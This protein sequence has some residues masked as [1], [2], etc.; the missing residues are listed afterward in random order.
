MPKRSRKT[1]LILLFFLWTV[2]V[3]PCSGN[4]NQIILNGRITDFLGF[5]VKYTNIYFVDQDND[6]LLFSTS[7]DSGGQY[8]IALPL[9]REKDIKTFTV[10]QNYPNPFQQN[11]FI[12]FYVYQPAEIEIRI[13]NILGQLVRSF[14]K[15]EYGAGI[16]QLE[17]NA[18]NDAGRRVH[19]GIYFVHFS[20]PRQVETLKTLLVEGSGGVSGPVPVQPDTDQLYAKITYRIIIEGEGVET[21][22]RE[23]ITLTDDTPNN[24]T[25]FRK[26]PVLYAVKGKYLSIWN[27]EDYSSVFMNGI[28]L[29]VAVPGT[30]PG[31]MAAT[32]EQYHLWLRQI[33]EVGFNSIRVYTLHYPR[34]YEKLAQYNRENPEHPILLFQGIWLDEEY[35]SADLFTQTEKFDDDLEEV[36]DCIHG[37]REIGHRFGRAYGQYTSDVSPWVMGYILGREIYSYEIIHTDSLHAQNVSFTGSAVELH[38]GTPT[39]TWLAARIDHSIVYERD[40]YDEQRPVSISSWPTLDPLKHPS[41][42]P[43]PYSQEDTV[44]I[45]LDNL[46]TQNAPAGY[47]AS[48]HAYPYYPDF[49]SDDSSYQQFSDAYGPNSYLGYLYDLNEHYQH[50]PLLIAEYGVPSSWGNA[51]DAHSGMDHGGL[52][53]QQQGQFDVRMI[54]NIWDTGCGGGFL[55]SWIDEWFKNAWITSPLESGADR[56]HF[57]HNVTA[58][59]QNYGL[60]K[61]TVGA[62]DYSQIA[63]KSDGKLQELLASAD[64]EF[65]YL[66]ILFSSEIQAS[67]TI[68]VAYDSYRSDLG[69]SILPNG[70]PISN[71]AEFALNIVLPDSARLYVT[72]AYDLFGIWHGVSGPQQFFHSIPSD[73]A[74]WIPVKWKNNWHEYSIQDIGNLRIRSVDETPTSLDAVV[75]SSREIE[76]RLPWTLLQVTDPSRLQVMDDERSTRERETTTTDGIAVTISYQNQILSS[77]R[78]TWPAWDIIPAFNEEEKASFQIFREGIQDIQFLFPNK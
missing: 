53:E 52:D 26:H 45:D 36:I 50:K 77:D 33:A 68:I 11:T 2:L 4:E 16:H 39:E 3:L 60:I 49:I 9:F 35:E 58:S 43:Y 74:P 41:E 47:F 18:H 75:F 22:S 7:T 37:N 14:E 19:S 10:L 59:E 32:R 25:V 51:H 67:D 44:S 40:T 66:K 17:W 28:N 56:R 46:E 72:Q 30:Q 64:N 20:T 27:G 65:F 8:S 69:E 57:W 73:G 34:F 78:Y 12:P 70:L 24:F 48:Y 61:F 29:G 42:R 15:A 31:E 62:P 63:R 55:F 76:I 1:I 5:P 38:E 13:Y 6:S 54:H 23:G 21:S 71:R